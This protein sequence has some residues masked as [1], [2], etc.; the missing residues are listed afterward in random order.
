MDKRTLSGLEEQTWE[1]EDSCAEQELLFFVSVN[2][3]VCFPVISM[4]LIQDREIWLKHTAST[5]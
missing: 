5:R 3:S 1:E 4:S 2:R